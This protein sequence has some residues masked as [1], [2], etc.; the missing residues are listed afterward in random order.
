MMRAAEPEPI[1]RTATPPLIG[2][3]VRR[4]NECR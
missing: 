4:L 1:E 2:I 3:P